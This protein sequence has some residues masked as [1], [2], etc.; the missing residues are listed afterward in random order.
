MGALGSNP[1]CV[2]PVDWAPAGATINP[3]AATMK[4]PDLIVVMFIVKASGMRL[5]SKLTSKSACVPSNVDQ[6]P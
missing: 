5:G 1:E 2:G 6:C 3:I 4:N